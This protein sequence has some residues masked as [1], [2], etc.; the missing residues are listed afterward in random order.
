MTRRGA[1]GARLDEPPSDRTFPLP[2]ERH[3]EHPEP[4]EPEEQQRQPSRQEQA[5]L[6]P[7]AGEKRS[8]VDRLDE[9]RTPIRHLQDLT[10]PQIDLHFI[11]VVQP[12]LHHP[13][14]RPHVHPVDVVPARDVHPG[15]L[16]HPRED[17]LDRYF[18]RFPGAAPLGRLHPG[19]VLLGLQ[20]Q[21]AA[22]HHQKR[23]RGDRA[24]PV[25]D[26]AVEDVEAHLAVDSTGKRK[27]LPAIVVVKR[28]IPNNLR[29][30]TGSRFAARGSQ[31]RGSRLAAC[32]SAQSQRAS[33]A[34]ASREQR[35][36]FNQS[37]APRARSL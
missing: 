17:I 28:S 6:G 24:R 36:R 34:A 27:L 12:D 31:A 11:P 15:N 19:R 1:P 37:S 29:T 22:D 21:P 33:A 7:V 14:A 13:A 2:P 10:R 25:V 20:Q 18:R 30:L 8:V 23:N 26:L 9:I 35:D 32:G 5:E 4:S 16:L 3:P